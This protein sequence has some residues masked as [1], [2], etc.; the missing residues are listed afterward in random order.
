MANMETLFHAVNIFAAKFQLYLMGSTS[1]TWLL[2][3]GS[4]KINCFNE[5]SRNEL[6]V[7]YCSLIP[8]GTPCTLT[9]Q[10]LK[11]NLNDDIL[12]FGKLVSTSNEI[13]KSN[14]TKVISITN[15]ETIVWSMEFE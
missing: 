15:S 2:S 11:W 6:Q 1:M 4:H 9:T 5:S 13:D 3:K 12:A 7:K 14:N 10:G 8:I